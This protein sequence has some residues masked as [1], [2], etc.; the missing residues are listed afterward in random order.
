M[1]QHDP[2]VTFRQMLDFAREA[3]MLAAGRTANDLV[4][5]RGFFLALSRLFEM[6]GEAARRIPSDVRDRYP[7]LRW[8]GMTGLRDWIAHGYDELDLDLIWD[9]VVNDLDPLIQRLERIIPDWPIED[10]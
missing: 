10:E 8:K 6:L 2:G 5:N 9:T 4:T 1:T 3:R 7:E